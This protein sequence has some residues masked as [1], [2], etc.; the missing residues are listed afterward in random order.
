QY[1]ISFLVYLIALFLF[2]LELPIL[3]SK[4]YHLLTKDTA[5]KFSFMNMQ[6]NDVL[7]GF[8]K[9]QFLLSIFIFLFFLLFLFLITS[10]VDCFFIWFVFDNYGCSLDHVTPY[11]G[12]RFNSDY[13]LYYHFRPLVI[14]HV[15]VR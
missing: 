12:H 3:N 11:L 5:E 2:M 6:L 4:M 7:I 9:E 8:I 13:W 10:D 1:I 15:S 14:I